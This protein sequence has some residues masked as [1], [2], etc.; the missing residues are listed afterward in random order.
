MCRL[1]QVLSAWEAKVQASPNSATPRHHSDLL[2]GLALLDYPLSDESIGRMMEVFA[3]G[4]A[5]MSGE[6]VSNVGW[7]LQRLGRPLDLLP[8]KMREEIEGEHPISAEIK[9]NSGNESGRR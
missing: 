6:D 5:K 7:A 4:H 8:E 1:T 2:L 3:Q 9:E